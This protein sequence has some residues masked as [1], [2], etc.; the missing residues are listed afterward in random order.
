MRFRN[1]IIHLADKS[2]FY[3]SGNDGI[4]A[5]KAFAKGHAVLVRGRCIAHHMI[6][7]IKPCNATEDEEAEEVIRHD[8]EDMKF[9]TGELK[10]EKSGDKYLLISSSSPQN[11]QVQKLLQ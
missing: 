5:M 9:I 1:Y 11:V 3:V 8:E 7:I 2:S 6:S 10:I 4:E